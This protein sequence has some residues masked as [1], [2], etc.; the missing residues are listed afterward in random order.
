MQARDYRDVVTGAVLMALGGAAAVYAATHY[1]LGTLNYM[2]PGLFPTAV[3]LLLAVFGAFILVPGLRR[4]GVVPQVE[5]RQAL[6]VLASI[7]AFALLAT[8][9]GLF[10]AAMGL[11]LV[12]SLGDDKV[13]PAGAAILGAILGVCSYGLFV[14]GLRLP[15]A[16]FSWPW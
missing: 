11:T 15:L 5:V 10:P 2:G 3:G 9:F 1:K 13:Q 12:A 7:A 14:V 6:A 4:A 8:S 16:A